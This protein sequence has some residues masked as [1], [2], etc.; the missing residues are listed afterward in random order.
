MKEAWPAKIISLVHPFNLSDDLDI[1]LEKYFEVHMP[2]LNFKIGLQGAKTSM[3]FVITEE[4]LNYN[5]EKDNLT[6]IISLLRISQH[7]R[8]HKFTYSLERMN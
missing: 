8:K 2:F 4:D 7:E 3:S 1:S 5:R 6:K